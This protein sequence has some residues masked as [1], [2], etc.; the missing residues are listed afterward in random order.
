MLKKLVKRTLPESIKAAVSQSLFGY[1]KLKPIAKRK[2]NICGYNGWFEAA[3][4]PP[5]LDARCPKC[6]SLERHRLLMLALQRGAIPFD[7]G[8]N[9]QVLHFAAEPAL[10]EI[11]RKRWAKYSTADL[12]AQADLILDIENIDYP[13][14]SVKVIIANHVLEHVDDI[15]AAHEL[16]R[17]LDDGGVLLC[18]VPIVEGWEST[19][20]NAAIDSEGLRLLHFGTKEHVR[21]YGRDFRKRIESGGLGLVSEITAF[22]DDVAKYG[23]VRGEKVFVFSRS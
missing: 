20:E 13:S 5:R 19:Y 11:F 8:K 23:L 18:M 6:F 21:F 17:I 1:R 10:Q 9:D 12:F 2:C 4:R 16:Y 22:G 7:V 15:K 14:K 3:G